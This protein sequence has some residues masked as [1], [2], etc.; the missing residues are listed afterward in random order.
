MSKSSDDDGMLSE[1]AIGIAGKL[2]TPTAAV[3]TTSSELSP[4]ANGVTNESH[5][6]GR[7]FVGAEG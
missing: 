3:S 4:V 6:L 7:I 2:K 5:G 1:T